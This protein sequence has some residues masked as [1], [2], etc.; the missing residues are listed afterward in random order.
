[1]QQAKRQGSK[2]NTW[3]GRLLAQSPLQVEKGR[4]E[5]GSVGSLLRF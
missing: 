3:S 1:M 5:N 4:E 2:A